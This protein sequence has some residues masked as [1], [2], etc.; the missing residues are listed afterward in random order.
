[1]RYRPLGRSGLTVSVVGLGCNNLG[2]VLD[3]A[4]T[5]KLLDAALDAGI[6]LLDVADTYGG[7]RGE[8]EEIL[9]AERLAALGLPACLV[10][11]GRAAVDHLLVPDD[12]MI[13]G[14]ACS[15]CG[16]LSAG[17]AR[18]SYCGTA[19]AAVPDLLEEMVQ[20]TLDDN[21]QVNVIR[22]A[23]FSVAAKLRFPVTAE[24]SR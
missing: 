7:H 19:A 8:S 13:P 14:F 17:P 10:A 5:R 16:Q 23:P 3:V 4:A 22:D 12:G 20:R 9:G 18:C 1:M 21:G 24:G 6:T 15:G 11:V 2:R